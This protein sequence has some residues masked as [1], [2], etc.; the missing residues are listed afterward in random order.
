MRCVNIALGSHKKKM[1]RDARADTHVQK[2]LDRIKMEIY[3]RKNVKKLSSF[4]GFY[5]K[6]PP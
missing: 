3:T 2:A 6:Y 1:F 5:T 4:L